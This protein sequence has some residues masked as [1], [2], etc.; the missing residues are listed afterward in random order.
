MWLHSDTR[1]G[2]PPY[3]GEGGAPFVQQL[4]LAARWPQLLRCNSQLAVHPHHLPLQRSSNGAPLLWQETVRRAG[5]RSVDAHGLR[6]CC[7][8]Q[9]LGIVGLWQAWL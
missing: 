3:L 7:I 4:Q 8:S 6:H 9:C 5:A 1:L 2:E